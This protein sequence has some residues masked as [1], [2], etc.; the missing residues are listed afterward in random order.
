M[1]ET[2]IG[3]VRRPGFDVEPIS[4]AEWRDYVQGHPR[5]RLREDKI[6]IQIPQ[7]GQV[8]EF[9]PQPGNVEF[10]WKGDWNN[11]FWWQR[12]SIRFKIPSECKL[13]D[14][15]DPFWSMVIE[16]CSHF[17][18]LIRDEFGDDWYNPTSGAKVTS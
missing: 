7:T 14:A 18:G 11:A 1:N 17:G 5:L 12:D 16:L 15:N 6:S 9:P 2:V 10:F 3:R 4:L 8:L 13:D